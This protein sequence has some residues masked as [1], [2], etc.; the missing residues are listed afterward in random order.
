MITSA[1]NSNISIGFLRKY[2]G[3]VLILSISFIFSLLVGELLVRLVFY[4]SMDFDM[5]MWK[6]A[7]KIKILSDDPQIGHEHRPN[8][9]EFL[10][11]VEVTTNS[12]GLRDDEITL[13]KPINTYRIIMLGDSITMGWGVA[14]SQ[15][16]PTQLEK[17]LSTPQMNNFPSSTHYEVLNLGVGNYNTVQEVASL[18]KKGLQFTPDMILLGYFINDAEPIQKAK[19][20]FLIENSYLY[21]FLA[22]RLKAVF[23]GG[24]KLN[25]EK[26]YK[27]LY[28]D[29]QVGW[30]AAKIALA[31]L[32]EIGK[33]QNIPILMFI[34]PELHDLSDTYPFLDV[35][36]KLV[37][38]GRKLGLTVIDLFPVFHNYSPEKELWVSAS[39]AHHNGLAQSMIA[40]GIYN[41]LIRSKIFLT[42]N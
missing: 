7:T 28:K 4:K 1:S 34:I 42:H 22:S 26:Y 14:Q 12:F 33:K 13:K 35:H 24:S 20:S 18:R 2:M 37:T 40:K 27:S 11:G 41:T 17:M 8:R 31:E 23:L 21:A 10:M 38:L 36:N 6:Y 32:V 5:E 39:D 29:D 19:V 15:L 3:H 25:Y 9:R 16:Y 30:Q